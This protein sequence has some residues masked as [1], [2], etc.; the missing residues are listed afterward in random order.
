MHIMA[1]ADSKTRG[2]LPVKTRIS[3]FGQ[4]DMFD[5]VVTGSSLLPT[6][7]LGPRH[8]NPSFVFPSDVRVPSRSGI[9]LFIYLSKPNP[10]P[11]R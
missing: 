1:S 7:T 9:L 11:L 4:V 8:K 3:N 10:S 2:Q 5:F 6:A